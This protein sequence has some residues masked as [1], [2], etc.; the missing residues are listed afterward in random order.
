MRIDNLLTTFGC[1]AYHR[2]LQTMVVTA[3]HGQESGTQVTE[4]GYEVDDG[5]NNQDAGSQSGIHGS[6]PI[7]GTKSQCKTPLNI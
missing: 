7:S 5:S 6:A 4:K 1:I 2:I 3:R